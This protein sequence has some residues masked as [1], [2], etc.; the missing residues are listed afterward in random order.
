MIFSV[1][2][3]AIIGCLWALGTIAP[4]QAIELAG[5]AVALVVIVGG[6]LF[7]IGKIAPSKKQ[8]SQ[9]ETSSKPGP[10]F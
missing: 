2:I 7:I 5:K 6:A 8:S 4:D 1:V 10:K 3:F 9:T